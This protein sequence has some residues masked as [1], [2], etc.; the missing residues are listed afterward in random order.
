MIG[1]DSW[2]GLPRDAPGAHWTLVDC[3]GVKSPA[4]FVGLLGLH[5]GPTD[6]LIVP[7]KLMYFVQVGL[8][9][10]LFHVLFFVFVFSPRW[11]PM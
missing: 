10:E 4:G 1:H 5:A 3:R 6:K 2:A 11:W 9:T 8:H 7:S